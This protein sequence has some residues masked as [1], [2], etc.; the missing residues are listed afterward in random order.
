[1]TK[2]R[3]SGQ[4]RQ[5][6][7]QRAK[8]YCEYC[9]C[10]EAYATQAHSIE[11]ILPKSRGGA[12]TEDNLALSC[13]GCNGSKYNKTRARDPATR[14]MAPLF[15]PRKHDWHDHFAWSPD[16]LYLTGLSPIGRA[17]IDALDLN[18]DGI[19]H[20]RSLLL[21]NREHPPPHRSSQ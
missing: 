10:P 6:V 17:T 2:Q 13:Q 14:R 11:H 21:L 8:G 20:L 12:S 19:I 15:H 4:L 16:C 18:R 9:L 7:R 1:M 5:L 3:I